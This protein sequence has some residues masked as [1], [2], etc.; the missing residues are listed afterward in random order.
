M[1]LWYAFL[2]QAKVDDDVNVLVGT[3][4]GALVVMETMQLVVRPYQTFQIQ[5][6]CD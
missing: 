1:R 4:C 2:V 6:I 3:H 5:L